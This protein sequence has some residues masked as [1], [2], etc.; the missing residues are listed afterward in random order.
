ME[1]NRKCFEYLCARYPTC[2]RAKY[3]RCCAIDFDQTA[4]DRNE[5][6]DQ[7]EITAAICNKDN[8]Y[9]YYIE[10]PSTKRYVRPTC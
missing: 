5:K 10:D 2:E 3:G 8:Q 9:A 4:Q 6:D 1:D 7:G